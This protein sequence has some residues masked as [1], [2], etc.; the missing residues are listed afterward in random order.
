MRK[1][2]FFSLGLATIATCLA[3]AGNEPWKTKPY[4]QWDQ[5]DIQQVLNNSPWGKVESV[6]ASWGSAADSSGLQP[7]GGYGQPT[8]PTGSQGSGAG[9]SGA[10][11][12]MGSSSPRPAGGSPMDNDPGMGGGQ[13]LVNFAVRWNSS[14][15]IREALA[16]DALLSN[17]I[18]EADAQKFVAQA[19]TDYEV[20]VSGPDMTPFAMANEAELK[21]KAF[22]EAKQSKQKVAPTSVKINRTPDEKKVTFIVFSFPR[23]ATA[24]Q[25]LVTPKDKNVEFGCRLKDLN[26]QASFDLRKM[27][28]DKGPDL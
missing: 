23:Q 5:K 11:G 8:A 28:T 6:P 17:K 18:S 24:N 2:I 19:P 16:R 14:Y 12:T 7:S 3:W 9:G 26:L 10:G 22:L 20:L 25:P 27:S 13:R 4:Q 21:A 1:T 15:T